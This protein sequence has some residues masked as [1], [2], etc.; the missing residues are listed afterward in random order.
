MFRY[1]SRARARLGVIKTTCANLN[2]RTRSG[3]SSASRRAAVRGPSLT[4][5]MILDLQIEMIR[6]VV[7][8]LY[9]LPLEQDFDVQWLRSMSPKLPGSDPYQRCKRPLHNRAAPLSSSQS[10]RRRG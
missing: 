6:Q 5:F 4:A 7:R 9:Q 10:R 8:L 2:G 1:Q 3:Y